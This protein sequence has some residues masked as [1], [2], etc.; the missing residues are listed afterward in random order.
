MNPKKLIEQKIGEQLEARI[1]QAIEKFDADAAIKSVEERLLKEAVNVTDALLGINRD[2]RTPQ[3]GNGLLKD[4]IEARIST[5]IDEKLWPQVEKQWEKRVNLKTTQ[6][7]IDSKIDSLISDKINNRL[8]SFHGDTAK[9]IERWVAKEVDNA[10]NAK[11]YSKS[12]K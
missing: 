1:I 12:P 6:A 2:W 3:I 10:V 8:N 4:S 11:L 7:A 9:Q 5:L